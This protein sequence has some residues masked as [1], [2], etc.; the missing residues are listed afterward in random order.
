MRNV[1][2]RKNLKRS[3]KRSKKGRVLSNNTSMPV[4][5]PIPTITRKIQFVAQAD[6][7]NN[8]TVNDLSKGCVGMMTAT[9]TSAYPLADA[10]RLLEVKVWTLPNTFGSSDPSRIKWIANS[11][12]D[13][14]T[15]LRLE[16]AVVFGLDKPAIMVARPPKESMAAFW[17]DGKADN[18]ATLFQL[19]CPNGSIIEITF[20][21]QT[22]DNSS[23]G[24]AIV[25]AG[26]AVGTLYHKFIFAG[27]A[28]ATGL[29]TIA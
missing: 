6:L 19:T 15:P 25:V 11:N 5:L 12:G 20:Q 4:A 21:Y 24:T 29:N 26:A 9:T 28:A 1:N 23:A 18:T 17:K 16:T 22:V 8:F 3:Q 10:V 7:N 14:Y 27:N 2:K 13:I